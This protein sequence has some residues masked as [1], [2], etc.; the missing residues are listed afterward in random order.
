MANRW[1]NRL[2]GDLQEPDV[3]VRT[4]KFENGLM[5]GKEYKT[6]RF[7]FT[8]AQS[9]EAFNFTEPLSSGLMGPVKILKEE[10]H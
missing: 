3:N 4:L 10:K 8:P 2:L 7:T 6:G 5:G 9:M 1:V